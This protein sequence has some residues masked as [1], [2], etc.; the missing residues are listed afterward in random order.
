MHRLPLVLVLGL[1]AA[2]LACAGPTPSGPRAG[3]GTP[4]AS[5][6]RLE[7]VGLGFKGGHGVAE[8][9]DR[10][11]VSD[12]YGRA[13]GLGVVSGGESPPQ[14][15]AMKG[16]SGPA[17]LTPVPGGGLLVC[18][19]TGSRIKLVD[20]QPTTL[21]SIELPAP[22][23]CTRLPSDEEA[24]LYAVIHFRGE[25]TLLR[26]RGGKLEPGSLLP[27]VGEFPFGIAWHPARRELLVTLQ[28]DGRVVRFPFD[29]GAPIRPMKPATFLDGLINP[30]GIAVDVAGNIWVAETA[31]HRVSVFAPDGE[32]LGRTPVGA[33]RFPVSI[34]PGRDNTVLVA[35]GGDSGRV[36]RAR[37]VPR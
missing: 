9:G 7:F 29:P 31:E 25:M 27:A 12:T 15:L 20:A 22:W 16:W 19:V 28:A 24:P 11:A 35:C 2:F 23:N 32:L 34:A 37:W 26:V 17:G 21:D 36:Y 18:D 4:S 5:G 13:P 33:L 1:A 6:I 14:T 3:E 30:E 8:W 10:I